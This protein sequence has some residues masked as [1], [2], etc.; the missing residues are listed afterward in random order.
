M[1]VITV[2]YWNIIEIKFTTPTKTKIVKDKSIEDTYLKNSICSK[3][4]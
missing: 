1:F 3:E 4:N 2:F